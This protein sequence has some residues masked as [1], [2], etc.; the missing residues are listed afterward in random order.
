MAFEDA[1]VLARAMAEHRHD[2]GRAFEVYQIKRKDRVER[3]AD[4]VRAMGRL[5]NIGNPIQA[6][7]IQ[8][9]GRLRSQIS[10]KG[11]GIGYGSMEV[12]RVLGLGESLADVRPSLW[13]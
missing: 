1:V 2:L 5:Y 8:A 12:R 4:Q 13:V 11:P 10:M 6:A 7:I 9:I 3:V